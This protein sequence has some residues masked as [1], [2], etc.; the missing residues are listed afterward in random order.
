MFEADLISLRAFFLCI[1]AFGV[2]FLTGAYWFARE[3]HRRGDF[4]K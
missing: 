4:K 3:A 1:A 2:G